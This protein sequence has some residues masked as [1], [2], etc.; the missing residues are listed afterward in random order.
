MVAAA[1]ACSNALAQ[2][3]T[4]PAVSIQSQE[5]QSGSLAAAWLGSSDARVRAWGAYLVLRDQRHELLPQ[6]RGLEEAYVVKDGSVTPPE[7]SNHDAMVGALD[8]IIQLGGSVPGSEAARLYLEFPAQSLILLAR[9][10]SQSSSGYLLNIFRL[11]DKRT[12][13]WLAAGNLLMNAKPS[14]FAAAVLEG[15]TV[16]A[17]V[18]IKDKGTGSD[19]VMGQGG[20][21]SSGL[22]SP[23][24]D[25]PAVGNY[26]AAGGSMGSSYYGKGVA[27]VIGGTDPVIYARNVGV[28][29]TAG[30][31]DVCAFR[32]ANRDV[33]REHFL[34]GL[35]AE[36]AG[37][38]TV[39]SSVS[40]TIL[41]QNSAQYLKDLRAFINRQQGLFDAIGRKLIAAGLLTTEEWASERP[42][43]EIRITDKRSLKQGDIP[44]LQNA[45]KGVKFVN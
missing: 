34:A 4:D 17:N 44:V 37:T 9:A 8:A 43:L 16:K 13:E 26:Y 24:A 2:T 3:S 41:W 35:A 12:G 22:P 42:S 40:D 45:G 1:T 6:L 36:P 18:Q 11:E 7:R 33:Y 28:A 38:P 27:A 19:P 30:R 31:Y 21:C 25:W 10:G 32:N 23:P 15:W 39:R 5:K 14:G 20:S 29:D